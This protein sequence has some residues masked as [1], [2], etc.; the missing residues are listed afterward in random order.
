MAQATRAD[1]GR[2]SQTDLGRTHSACFLITT[3]LSATKY[4]LEPVVVLSRTRTDLGDDFDARTATRTT[5]NDDD[6]DDDDDDDGD[7]DDGN[8]S[9]NNHNISTTTTVTTAAYHIVVTVFEHSNAITAV[10]LVLLPERGGK[11]LM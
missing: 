10:Y 11:I 9:N 7:D 4:L 1:D 5:S 3:T 6:D 8:N 2:E